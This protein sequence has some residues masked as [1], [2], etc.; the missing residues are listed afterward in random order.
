M[1]RKTVSHY[2]ILKKLGGAPVSLPPG[3]IFGALQSGLVDAAEFLG[4]WSDMAQ[5]FYRV[6]P[7]YYAPGFHEPNGTGECLISAKAF[8]ELPANLQAIVSDAC[9]A[10]NA[11]SVAEADWMNGAS[12][13]MLVGEHGVKLRNYPAEV[14]DAAREAAE[15]VLDE[16]AASDAMFAKILESYRAAKVRL[17][18]WTK[19]GTQ[20]FLAARG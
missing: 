6:A 17:G 19:T 2:K 20:S 3:E 15:T 8:A 4:P 10:E 18:A 1:I 9:A 16:A 11:L 5:G 7:Y 13:D 14:L 12:L